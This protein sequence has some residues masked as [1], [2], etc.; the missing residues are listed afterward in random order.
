MK[1]QI[2]NSN[3]ATQPYY[4][5]IVADNGHVLA[6]SETYAQKQSCHDAINIVKR[7]AAGA[8]IE[9]NT[10]QAAYRRY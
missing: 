8:V 10:R 5:R 4:W 9:D 6:H 7:G 3:S 2:L 1:F